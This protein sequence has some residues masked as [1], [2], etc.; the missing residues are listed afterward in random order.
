MVDID[1]KQPPYGCSHMLR[2]NLLPQSG[3]YAD[4]HKS[5][6]ADAL[7]A[8]DDKGLP[9]LTPAYIYMLTNEAGD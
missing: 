7:Q 5:T 3:D 6:A 2:T 1:D 8:L 9:R 4:A